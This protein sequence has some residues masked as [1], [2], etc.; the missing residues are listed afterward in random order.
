[1][2][3]KGSSASYAGILQ[4]TSLSLYLPYIILIL[5]MYFACALAHCPAALT[6][7]F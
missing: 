6:N 4:C 7:A 2:L 1:M 5:T 3:T